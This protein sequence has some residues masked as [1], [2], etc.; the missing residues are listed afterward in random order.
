MLV[1]AIGTFTDPAKIGPYAEA[2]LATIRAHKAAGTVA[3]AY[4]RADGK[5]VALVWRVDNLAE[6][7]EHIAR[8]LFSQHGLMTV[9]LVEIAEL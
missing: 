8:L 6:A 2:E 1:L 5:G 7:R 4:Q 3:H 9:E